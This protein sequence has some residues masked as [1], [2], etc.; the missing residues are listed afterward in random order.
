MGVLGGGHAGVRVQHDYMGVLG[1]GHA[2]VQHDYMGG[3]QECS[4]TIWGAR[5]SAA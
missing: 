5:R 2:G 4:M 1:G 3:T